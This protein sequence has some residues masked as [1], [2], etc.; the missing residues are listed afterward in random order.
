MSNNKK[1]VALLRAE[2]KS[3]YSKAYLDKREKQE[4]KSKLLNIQIPDYLPKMSHDKFE[5]LVKQLDRIGIVDDVDADAIARYLIL[6]R[7]FTR[8]QSKIRQYDKKGNFEEENNYHK[9]ITT[10]GKLLKDLR[11]HASDLGLNVTARGK[12][13]LPVS[14]EEDKPMSKE[15]QLFGSALGGGRN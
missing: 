5:W 10:Q 14:A 2:G 3:N 11:A 4:P 8:V 13:T 12:I 7:Q 1:P 15:E 9:L 6:E